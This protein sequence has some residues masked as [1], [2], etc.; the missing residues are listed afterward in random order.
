MLKPPE[1]K[2]ILEAALLASQEPVSATELK[3][4]FDGELPFPSIADPL[5]LGVYPSLVAG[6]LLILAGSWLSTDG[7]MPPGLA[8]LLRARPERRDPDP[9]RAR[10]LADGPQSRHQGHANGLGNARAL[11]ACPG[12]QA[13]L[14][15]LL[16]KAQLRD[17]ANERRA[18]QSPVR[19]ARS[20]HALQRSLS[21]RRGDM[22]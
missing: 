22:T 5:Y 7:R 3:R 13:D 15:G 8:W 10:H 19:D 11:A 6:L 17:P 9:G 14:R 20:Q 4:L 18:I 16:G 12:D 21:P 1:A 2:R